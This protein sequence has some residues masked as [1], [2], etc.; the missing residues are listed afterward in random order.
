MAQANG[1]TARILSGDQPPSRDSTAC[2]RR[3]PRWFFSEV[4]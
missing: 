4:M 2:E 1:L 3:V